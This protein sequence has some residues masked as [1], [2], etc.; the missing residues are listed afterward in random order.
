MQF[1]GFNNI[2]IYIYL[3]IFHG[4]T[5]HLGTRNVFYLPTDAQ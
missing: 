4:C 3:F 1:V 2:C 5:V